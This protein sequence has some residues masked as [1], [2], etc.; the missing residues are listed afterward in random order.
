MDLVERFHEYVLG[1]IDEKGVYPSPGMSVDADGKMQVAALCEPDTA[2][3]W[4]WNQVTIKQA[5]ECIF[6]LDRSTRDGQGTEFADVLTCVHWKEGMDGKPWD[7]SFRIGV[8]NYQNDPRIVR[9]FDFANEFWSEKMT[10]EAK[11]FR[12][13]FR[14]KVTAAS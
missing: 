3:N 13:S 5:K 8:I 14:M 9:P 4:F 11:S 2:F 6:G 1:M 10:G 7:T 12:P